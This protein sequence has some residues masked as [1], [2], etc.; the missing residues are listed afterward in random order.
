[1]KPHEPPS[2]LVRR[3]TGIRSSF[4][5]LSRLTSLLSLSLRYPRRFLNPITL[6]PRIT[7]PKMNNAS[8]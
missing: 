8:A 5:T 3:F 6:N 4:A 7:T 1:M 2:T